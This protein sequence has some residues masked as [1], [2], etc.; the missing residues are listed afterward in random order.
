MLLEERERQA[1]DLD[2]DAAA[3]HPTG[4]RG[5]RRSHLLLNLVTVAVAFVFG[6]LFAVAIL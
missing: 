6:T 5:K 3:G 1:P 2:V 4:R